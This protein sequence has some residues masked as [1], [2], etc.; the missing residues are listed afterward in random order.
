MSWDTIEH[1]IKNAE[2]DYNISESMLA[3]N[4]PAIDLDRLYILGLKIYDTKFSVDY[5]NVN[6]GHGKPHADNGEHEHPKVIKKEYSCAQLFP[7]FSN[8]HYY[9]LEDLEAH[10]RELRPELK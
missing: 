10:I 8:W 4:Y 1:C 3:E 9:N 7:T 5:A 6:V 2:V